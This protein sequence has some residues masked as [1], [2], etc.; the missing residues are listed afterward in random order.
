MM[1]IRQIET[2]GDVFTESWEKI[3]ELWWLQDSLKRF[4]RDRPDTREKLVSEGYK[5]AMVDRLLDKHRQKIKRQIEQET[6]RMQ[7]VYR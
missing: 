7:E 4:D 6:E 5:P 3:R 2:M 1:T